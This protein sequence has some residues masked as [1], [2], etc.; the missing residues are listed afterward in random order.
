MF[1]DDQIDVQLEVNDVDDEPVDLTVK[2]V[3]ARKF[4]CQQKVHLIP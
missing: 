4:R 1:T 3:E 2:F